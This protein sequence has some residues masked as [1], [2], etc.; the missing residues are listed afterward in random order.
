[1]KKKRLEQKFP[2][3]E[4]KKLFCIMKLTFFFFLLSSNLVWAAQTYAQVTS[5]NLEL[6]NVNLE[7][8]FEAIRQ[9]SEFEFFYNNDQVNTLVKVSVKAKNADIKT[10]LEQALPAIY[11]YKINDRYILI[12]KRKEIAPVL[13]PQPQQT[14]KTI[15]GK[16]T[17]KEGESII[18]A[19][20]VEVGTTNGTVTNV[21]G[22]FTL[23]VEQDAV[24]HI[25][26]IGYLSQDIN[27]SGKNT[28]SIVLEEDATILDEVVAIGYGTVRKSDLTGSVSTVSG[29]QF[30]DQPVKRV[31]DILQGRS[32]GV[33]VT[34]LSGMPGAGMKVR[35]RGTTSINKSSA[36]LYV[37]DGIF[38]SSGL[39]GLNPSDIRSIEVL[40]DASATAIYGS[41]GAN[42]VILVTTRRGETGRA[43][44]TFD[45]SIGIS[46]MANRYDVL[47]AYEYATALND[48]W[49]AST[50]SAADLE[51]YKIGQKGIDWQDLMTQRGVS[52]DYKLSI[53]G[54][55]TTTRYLVS[56]NILDQDAITITTKY[57]RN[58]LRANLDSEVTPWLTMSTKLNAARMHTHNG[59]VDLMNAINF[60]PTMELTNEETGVYNKD[61]YNAVGDN[62]YGARM[63]NYNDNYR[64][65][66]NANT[67]LLFKIIDGL[68]LAVTG[69]YNYSHNPSY[70]FSSKLRAPGALS[71]MSNNSGMTCYW[72]NT[73]NLTYQK[74]FG[75]HNI[76]ATAVW[77]ISN[78]TNTY[79]SV[80]GSNLSNENIVGYWNVNNAAT[81]SQS[82][83]YS[84]ESMASGVAR[85]MYNY[86]GRYFLTGTFRTDGSSKFQG[87]NKWG[88][89]PSGAIAWDMAK[90]DFMSTQHIFQQ[91]KLR[92]SFGITG[93][94]DI[95]RYSTLGMLS[96]T[97]YGWGTSTDYTGYWGDSFATPDVRWEKTYQYDLG[98]D[99]GL[100]DNRVNLT[101][102]WFLKQSKDLLFR[103]N[104][105]MYN[106]GGSFWVN[107]GEV[108]NS[109]IEFSVTAY[110]LSNKEVTWETNFNATYVKNEVVDLAGE[111]FILDGIN[112]ALG[113]AMQIMKPGY[114]VGS[115][116]LHKWKGFDDTGANLYETADGN[117]TTSPTGEDQFIMGQASPAWT[118]GWNNMVSWKNWS[119]N[120]FINAA[121]GFNRLNNTHFALTSMVG[122]FR[123]IS[124]RDAYYKGWDYVD[125]K[126]EAEYPS[127]TNSD[128]K[129]YGNSDQWL[130]NASYI[131]LK[132]ISVSYH[133]PKQVAKFADVDLTVSGQD[134]LTL[135]NYKGMDPEVYNSYTGVD[136]GAY[137]VPRTFTFGAKFTF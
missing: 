78:N 101:L 39:E 100:L 98:I 91:M 119:V 43:Q 5:L 115:F 67:S 127:H 57:K 120:I 23:R 42:G 25:S 17:D 9:Q 24:L 79:L 6:N 137:P 76:T 123:F 38:S 95:D 36:P 114:P 125:N 48:I 46:N 26:Y 32:S 68:T 56:A 40:K 27:T 80:S 122:M 12:N 74:M 70:S 4:L 89:F 109:G 73:N 22:N 66:L 133:I 129:Y 31:E 82:N 47:N 69:G 81:K 97:S 44:I 134:I 7:E 126:A 105:P 16:I 10:V 41:R 64:Y 113:G 61:P 90:E 1:M 15:T 83:S 45:A 51:A 13:S 102:D 75:N 128:T 60:S 59:S 118:F 108:K 87:N 52:R 2:L 131:K 107:Q 8:V 96:T 53:S 94:Q 112:S 55:S 58:S 29:K 30:S 106:G 92:A 85:I 50:I 88:Y 20:I 110:P 84:E 99:M 62:P 77:E 28:F 116:Y 11:E 14:K 132:N 21:D 111:E 93:N 86:G 136:Y 71:G 121:S 104:V 63:V 49:G 37:V 18:G 19:N 103:K 117:L 135:T 65:Y 72:Q 34:T 33:E 54:G 3:R 35:V 124:L 130:E